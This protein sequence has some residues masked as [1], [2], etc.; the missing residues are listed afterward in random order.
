VYSIQLLLS[1]SAA[2]VILQVSEIGRSFSPD[3]SVLATK[4]VLFYIKLQFLYNG[5][6]LV[7]PRNAVEFLSAI[8]DAHIE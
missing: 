6:F 5:L 1:K 3:D 8:D 2:R 7:N 4:E